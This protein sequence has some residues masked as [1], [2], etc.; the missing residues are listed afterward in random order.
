MRF[1]IR[2]FAHLITNSQKGTRLLPAPIAKQHAEDTV[3]IG[4][5]N[6]QR[7]KLSDITYIS[8]DDHGNVQ[9]TGLTAYNTTAVH[10]Q[11]RALVL[12]AK[13]R[14]WQYTGLVTH[15]D[16]HYL[17]YC[18][19]HHPDH[20]N[21]IAHLITQRFPT[22]L[23]DEY[24]D[25]NY[26]LALTIKRLFQQQH[27]HGLIVGDTDQAI[28]EFGGAHPRLFDEIETIQGAA[29]FP[30][31]KTY[32]CP[33][34]VASVATHL[35]HSHNPVEPTDEPGH[36]ILLAHNDDP[37]RLRD[38]LVANA[39]PGERITI[40]ARRTDT[41]DNLKGCGKANFPGGCKLAAQI[42]AAVALLPTSASKAGQL[43]SAALAKLLLND[44]FPTKPTLDAHHTSP[45]A[46][47]QAVWH[48]LTDAAKINSGETWQDWVIRMRTAL[49]EAAALAGIPLARA[50]ITQ[51]LRTT[52]SMNTPRQPALAKPAT[53]WPDAT[54]FSTIHGVKGDEFEVV[55]LYY[56]KP[57]AH[58][59]LQCITRQWW[60][61]QATEERRV[62]F[63]ATTRAKR[64]FILCVHQDTYNALEAS[65]SAFFAS[66]NDHI[67][68]I[69]AARPAPAGRRTR[70]TVLTT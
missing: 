19:L 49:A 30:L 32:R 13:R 10:G 59:L 4:T 37:A 18:I 27:V 58:G 14:I 12:R 61:N 33:A 7:S 17:A 45:Q 70:Q 1:I 47:R 66:F 40:L 23:V 48:L 9:M 44:Y 68:P 29:T 22:I 51:A 65:Q 54:V 15:S 64:V 26:F 31:R 21:A 16:T 24:Q 25:T 69:A 6:A 57:S 11:Q 62:A 55:A 63:V 53:I 56:P 20:G 38:A 5:S 3:Q 2:P 52:A 43:A 39:Q 8:H 28:Y 36:S 50:R 41:I 67:A 34:N 60:N 35:A 42:S 46:W